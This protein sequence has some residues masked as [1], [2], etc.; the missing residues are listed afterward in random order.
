MNSTIKLKPEDELLICCARTQMDSRTA[1]NVCNLVK[2]DLEWDYLLNMASI[3]SLR[4]LLYFQLSHLCSEDVPLDIMDNLRDYTNFNVRNNLLMLGELLKILKLIELEGIITVP[5]KGPMLAINMYG[6]LSLREFVDLDIFVDQKDVI[7]VK[8]I[9][10]SSGYET[11]LNLN[12]KREAQYLKLQREYK[13]TNKDNGVSVE[14][15]WNL[16]LIS[17][18]FPKKRV[19][20]LNQIKT[21]SEINNQ[22]ILSFSDEDLLLILSLHS[23]THLWDKL[24][25]ICDIAELIKNS[26]GLN[27]DKILEKAHYLA[28][29]RI[30]YLNLALASELF[31]IKLPREIILKIESDYKINYL[32]QDV[33]KGFFDNEN[34]GFLQKALLRFRIRERKRD[35]INDFIK[36]IIMPSSTEWKTFQNP[37]PLHLLYILARPIQIFN[38]VIR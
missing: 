30:L 21:K 25:L 4:S 14:I 15:Q 35:R 19:F 34:Y 18:S 5:Y 31:D 11:K 17:L 33:M 7:K 20:A 3:H 37:I 1:K 8:K 28:V 32:K 24:S 6:D 12:T 29:E 10:I 38:K 36:I 26:K 16:A 27:W 22:N 2:K 13:F 23:V 9:L